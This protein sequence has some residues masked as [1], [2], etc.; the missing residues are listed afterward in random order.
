MKRMFL[1]IVMLVLAVPAAWGA[2]RSSDAL[3]IYLK[4]GDSGLDINP[5]TIDWPADFDQQIKLVND[6]K[7]EFYCEVSTD[8]T[9]WKIAKQRKRTGNAPWLSAMYDG[10]EASARM[11]SVVALLHQRGL[12]RDAVRYIPVRSNR[13]Y[14][15]IYAVALPEPIQLSPVISQATTSSGSPSSCE[16]SL[17]VGLARTPILDIIPIIQG[18]VIYQQRFLLQDKHWIQK[19]N[20]NI[21]KRPVI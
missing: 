9:Q 2:E 14:V 8:T 11:Q 13:C 4:P 12:V 19:I 7:A 17:M 18:A 15:K 3:V 21:K 10:G 1:I 5:A 16:L 20:P 6:G